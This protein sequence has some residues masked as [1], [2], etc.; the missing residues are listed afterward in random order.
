MTTATHDGELVERSKRWFDAIPA[1]RHPW[2]R[3]RD[4][5]PARHLRGH[6]AFDAG[7][8]SRIER[9][10]EA[11]DRLRLSIVPTTKHFEA[12][13]AAFRRYHESRERDHLSRRLRYLVWRGAA[14]TLICRRGRSQDE[15]DGNQARHL[16]A[17]TMS[18]ISPDITAD[19]WCKGGG[20][21]WQ[22]WLVPDKDGIEKPDPLSEY[23]VM[24]ML[25]MKRA[26]V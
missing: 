15:I 19:G 25:I 18:A 4:A 7:I 1:S 9:L 26:Y 13:W 21:F 10:I 12:M 14:L 2:K 16:L 3:W 24:T 5:L 17:A 23:A 8:E 6:T 11:A 20:S 22:I